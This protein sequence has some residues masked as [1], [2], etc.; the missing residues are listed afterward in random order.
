MSVRTSGKICGTGVVAGLVFC[1]VGAAENDGDMLAVDCVDGHV[2]VRANAVPARRVLDELSRRCDIAVRLQIPL[3]K[4]I[5]VNF[6]ELPLQRAAGRLLRDRS[7][8]LRYAQASPGASNWLWVF[9]DSPDASAEA[10]GRQPTAE[11]GVD[12]FESI[13]SLAEPK[14]TANIDALRD[15]LTDPDRD[16]REA[17]V[18]TLAETEADEA[19]RA[20]TIAL[21][22]P[23]P[24]IRQSVLDALGQIGGQTAIQLLRQM[25]HD[26]DPVLREAAADNLA[27]LEG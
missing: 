6:E 1:A 7:F 14:N 22:D 18:E 8:I 15:A 21:A 16:I 17:A 9:A 19:A 3:M 24:E 11:A 13:Y 27:E 26:S 10:A 4:D 20:L 5:T 12:K 23:D 25:L 2:S